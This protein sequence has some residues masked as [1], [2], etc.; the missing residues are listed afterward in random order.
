MKFTISW[1]KDHL[2]TTATV[3]EI[4]EACTDLGLEVEEI[5][6]P[7]D[8]LGAFTIAKVKSA[9]KHPDATVCVCAR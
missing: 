3:D 8:R 2:D 5:F 6:N 4:A 1:L 9:E 7:M